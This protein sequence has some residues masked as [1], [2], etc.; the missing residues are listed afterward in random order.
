MTAPLFEANL[1]A[2]QPL[3]RRLRPRTI[4]EFV[5]QAHVMGP[6][7]VVDRIIKSRHLASLIV[8]GPPGTGKT[9]LA[10]LLAGIFDAAFEPVNAVTSGVAEIR[11]ISEEA[12]S[13]LALHGRRTLL[14]IDEIHR[15]NKAQQDA[16]LP[17]VENG[18]LILIGATTHNPSFYVTAAL[19][20]R[21]S[22]VEFHPLTVDEIL[23]LLRRALLEKDRG[24][25][26]TGIQVE[27]AALRGL[28]VTCDGDARRALTALELAA[29][30][31]PL[32]ATLGPADLEAALG[33]RVIRHDRDED[34]HYD[35]ASAFI[36]SLRGSDPDAAVYYLARLLEGGD[37]PRFLARRLAI[38]ASEDIGN[39]DAKALLVA[40][41][42]AQALEFV[43]MPEA[44]I[45]LSQAA[46]YLASAPKSNAAY[47]AIDAALADV[48]S[49][50]LLEVPNHLRGSSYRD[51][52]R[53][54]RGKDYRYPHD[55]GGFVKQEYLSASRS[56]Y[57]PAGHGE[58]KRLLDRL[59]ALWG[60]WP[61]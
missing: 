30:T 11:R 54:G 41:A 40:V 19:A 38:F 33:T 34:A 28:A 53:L 49:G 45:I 56:F 24:L 48:R 25:G 4:E 42:A 37:D 27:E 10:H 9:A 15:F 16:L 44:R 57:R 39:A 5:G 6:G 60:S 35:C 13:R 21:T 22:F 36:K 17:D 12:A 2:H 52:E 3:A 58:E 59:K 1:E 50:R 29:A 51:A 43:G 55:H 20:S 14:F 32:G 31:A 23:T 61:R 47:L 26:A 46:T 18:R 8:F 7:R